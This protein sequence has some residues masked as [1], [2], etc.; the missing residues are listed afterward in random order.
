MLEWLRVETERRSVTSR[1]VLD[2]IRDG[3][4]ALALADA[5]R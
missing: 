4:R 3:V 1:Q 2:E 5:S